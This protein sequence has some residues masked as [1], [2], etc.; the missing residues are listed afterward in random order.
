MKSNVHLISV[1]A[2]FVSACASNA[3]APELDP[4]AYPVIIQPDLTPAHKLTEIVGPV[5]R[6]FG[7]GRIRGTIDGVDFV[8]FVEGCNLPKVDPRVS[9]RPEISRV[10]YVRVSGAFSFGVMGYSPEGYEH[11]AY[12][13]VSDQSGAGIA[14]GVFPDTLPNPPAPEVGRLTRHCS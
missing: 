5:P 12:Y 3:H 4:I 1:F 14:A 10:W 11:Y 2:L 6:P 7:A 8:A 13:L 9:A